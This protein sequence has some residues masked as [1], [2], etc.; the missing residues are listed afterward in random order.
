MA[1]DEMLLRRFSCLDLCRIGISYKTTLLDGEFFELKPGRNVVTCSGVA[2]GTDSYHAKLVDGVKLC[3]PECYVSQL[4]NTVFTVYTKLR[5]KGASI[6]AVRAM[7]FKMDEMQIDDVKHVAS[8]YH[9]TITDLI[10]EAVSEYL[11][12]MKADP[13]YRLTA[14]VEEADAAESAEILDAIS[15]MEDDD[16]AIASSERFTV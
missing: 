10:K 4:D 13:F 14:N 1:S 7:N 5:V 2:A 12:K 15:S 3:L 11:I 8:V 9:M 6:M 16:L